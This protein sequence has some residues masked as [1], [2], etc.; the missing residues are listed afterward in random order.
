MQ[1]QLELARLL[2]PI[3]VQQ[4]LRQA[5]PS[6]SQSSSE[7]LQVTEEAMHRAKMVIDELEAQVPRT[8]DDVFAQVC[9]PSHHKVHSVRQPESSQTRR[10]LR[11]R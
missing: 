11:G 7:S 10:L 4:Q 8:V 5:S 9:R 2:I 3:M 1:R 6:V